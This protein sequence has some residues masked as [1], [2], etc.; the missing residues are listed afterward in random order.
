[1]RLSSQQ[2]PVGSFTPE[3]GL[4]ESGGRRWR[5]NPTLFRHDPL[6]LVKMLAVGLPLSVFVIL[7]F[8]LALFN[9]M[10]G[11][12]SIRPFDVVMLI[13]T[14]SI[15][16]GSAI[17]FYPFLLV[18]YRQQV[19]IEEESQKLLAKYREGLQEFQLRLAK[20][21]ISPTE[22]PWADHQKILEGMTRD[23]PD[24]Q[25]FVY[26]YTTYVTIEGQRWDEIVRRASSG[27][28]TYEQA[29]K[30]II[31]E[32]VH[33]T[34]VENLED[35]TYDLS[36]Y[37]MPISYCMTAVAFG[38]FVLSLIPL[39]GTG[40]ISFGGTSTEINLVWAAG[41]FVGA[42]IYSFFPFFQRLTRGDMPPR[43]FLQYALRIFLGTVAVAVFGNLF[44]R[45]VS[46]GAIEFA[47]AVVL[48]SVPF[49]VLSESRKYLLPK[50][51]FAASEEE[52]GCQDVST[53]SGITY[54]YAERLHE[55]GIINIQNLAFADPDDLFK[56]TMLNRRMLFDWKDQAILMLLTGT[57]DTKNLKKTT[58]NS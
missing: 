9:Q 25:D 22:A 33:A 31:R 57:I 37:F 2:E 54:D 36:S 13:F 16:L 20:E 55:E 3:A 24:Y 51:G 29:G 14:F 34:A 10:S 4:K 38:F 53:I 5:I 52:I 26:L 50:M 21:N 17:L 6:S 12:Y 18:H 11:L 1:M 44:L 30:E 41:G 15:F 7:T 8:D 39:F 47:G 28:Q 45:V 35:A 49:L 58:G 19:Y 23:N 42:Y 48:G 43:A 32:L 46:D 40:I 56:K 27:E